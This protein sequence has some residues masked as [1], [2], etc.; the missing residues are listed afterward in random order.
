MALRE[1]TM[2]RRLADIETLSGGEK[3]VLMGH[4]LHL[5]K[6]DAKLLSPVPQA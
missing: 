3:L 2:K 4:A 5:A 1:D 6:D